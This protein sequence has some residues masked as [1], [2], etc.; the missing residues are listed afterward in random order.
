MADGNHPVLPRYLRLRRH[1][2]LALVFLLN[3]RL[4]G[5]FLYDLRGVCFP[6]LNCWACPTAAVACPLGALQNAIGDMRAVLIL[7][8]Y[9]LGSIIAASAVL[10][11]AGVVPTM[12]ASTQTHGQ[13][14]NWHPHVHA[15]TACITAPATT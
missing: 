1:C 4:S 3:A 12:V 6:A 7:P 15:M 9:I 2:Q 10:G 8:L 5:R 14:S 11:R 13:L